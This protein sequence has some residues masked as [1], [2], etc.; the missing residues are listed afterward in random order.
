MNPGERVQLEEIAESVCGMTY[1]AAEVFDDP[2]SRKE[3]YWT[4]ARM[5]K[6]RCVERGYGFAM[7]PLWLW[8][9][10]TAVGAYISWAIQREL[11]KRFKGETGAP[12]CSD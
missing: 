3:M 10:T 6:G 9:L 11:D 8:L 1:A 5:A 7:M 12:G 4:A 2:Q